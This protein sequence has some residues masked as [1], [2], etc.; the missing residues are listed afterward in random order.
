MAYTK[1]LFY[2]LD[3]LAFREGIDE[4]VKVNAE[5]RAAAAPSGSR[6]NG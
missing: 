5:A 2:A 3:G 6:P 4:G 1:R